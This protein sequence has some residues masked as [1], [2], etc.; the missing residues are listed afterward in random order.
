VDNFTQ[1]KLNVKLHRKIL[2]LCLNKKDIIKKF[3][4][5]NIQSTGSFVPFSKYSWNPYSKKKYKIDKYDTFTSTLWQK[6]NEHLISNKNEEIIKK[7]KK[8]YKLY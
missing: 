3:I 5:C 7:F 6:L 4:L 8:K 2:W 1:Q